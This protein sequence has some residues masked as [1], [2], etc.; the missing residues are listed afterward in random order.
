M[1]DRKKERRKEVDRERGRKREWGE[2]GS[3][4]CLFG[5]LVS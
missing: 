1:T 4:L 5:W 3:F 2:G